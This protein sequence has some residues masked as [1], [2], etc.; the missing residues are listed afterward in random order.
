MSHSSP[1]QIDNAIQRYVV[2]FLKPSSDKSSQPTR[3]SLFENSATDSWAIGDINGNLGST[4]EQWKCFIIGLVLKMRKSMSVI[5]L[6]NRIKNW[7]V[8]HTIPS[9][10][11]YDVQKIQEDVKRLSLEPLTQSD[12]N[13][14]E[15]D[16]VNLMVD[17][18]GREQ[19]EQWV[20]DFLMDSTDVKYSC[21]RASSV[22]FSG[23]TMRLPIK[24]QN[25][26]HLVSSFAVD[27]V[28]NRMADRGQKH[29]HRD[30]VAVKK[31]HWSLANKNVSVSQVIHEVV[32]PFEV[33]SALSGTYSMIELTKVLNAFNVP[34]RTIHFEPK[35]MAKINDAKHYKN[36]SRL[37]AL[38]AI[39]HYFMDE[40]TAEN[41]WIRNSSL[42]IPSPAVHHSLSDHF[43]I[44]LTPAKRTFSDETSDYPLTNKRPRVSVVNRNKTPQ[45]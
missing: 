2:S 1:K 41:Q 23:T 5:D 14:W 15:K 31:H 10:C 24:R 13:Q 4:E 37:C 22:L 16:I 26:T 9:F 17:K 7:S 33:T 34:E 18:V 3:C 35:L 12:V 32:V 44:R 30:R 28:K 19:F 39:L 27:V 45:T 43:Q 21:Y 11:P 40:L 29:R 38:V 25:W 6:E 42:S 8:F 20:A 36:A